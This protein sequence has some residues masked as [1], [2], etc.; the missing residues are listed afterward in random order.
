MEVTKNIEGSR[1]DEVYIDFSKAFDKFAHGRLAL[2]LK[3]K[4]S[5][6]YRQTGCKMNLVLGGS[7]LLSATGF[8]TGSL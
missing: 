8:L 7:S 1:E 2:K 6:T 5:N 3:R 4:A